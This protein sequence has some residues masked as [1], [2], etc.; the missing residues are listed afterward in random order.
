MDIAFNLLNLY[1]IYLI[2]KLLWPSSYISVTLKAYYLEIAALAKAKFIEKITM[3]I[4]IIINS[5]HSY[6]VIFSL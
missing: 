2:V 4:Y 6:I 5:F 1:A 3:F